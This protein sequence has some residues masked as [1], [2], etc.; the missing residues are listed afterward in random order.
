MLPYIIH[1]IIV[2]YQSKITECRICLNYVINQR[3]ENTIFNSSNEN[4]LNYT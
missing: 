1:D 4:I 2:E 3:N